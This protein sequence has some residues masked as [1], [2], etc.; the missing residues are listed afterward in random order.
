M[1]RLRSQTDT[2]AWALFESRYG[3]LILAYA[4]KRGLQFSDAEDVRQMVLL[5][6]SRTFPNFS[7]D[8]ARGRFRSYLGTSVRHAI[9]RHASRHTPGSGGLP[10]SD[11]TD[12]IGSHH[13][14][15]P[16]A[17][18]TAHPAATSDTTTDELWDQQ[19]MRHHYR[20]AMQTLQKTAGP[21][22]VRVIE[23]FMNGLSTGAIAHELSISTQAVRKTKQR[24]KDRLTEIVA[25]QLADEEPG[26]LPH[27]Q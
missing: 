6:M 10:L 15:P 16:T 7:Y 5:G 22:G 24:M 23:A 19:W 20:L 8:P 14:T 3:P 18:H 25:Q 11:L 9:S 2:E 21:S 1:L 12:S 27:D 13:T 26:P 17:H 4:L